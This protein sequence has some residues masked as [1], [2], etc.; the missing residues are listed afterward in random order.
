MS[1]LPISD[2]VS[3]SVSLSPASTIAAGFNIGC[4]IGKS[5]I[6][7]PII[8]TKAYTNV[9]DMLTDGFTTGSAEYIAAQ[10]YFAQSPKPTKVIIGRWDG[11]GA[12]TAVQ[13]PT[14]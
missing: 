2:V 10:L 13:S 8:R 6:I 12:E 3:V 14:D 1:N 11:T 7:T 5:T 9:A 4:I